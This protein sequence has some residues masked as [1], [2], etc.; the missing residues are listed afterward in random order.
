MNQIQ[1]ILNKLDILKNQ[2]EKCSNL[3][4]YINIRKKMKTER[5]NFNIALG[6]Y[7]NEIHKIYNLTKLNFSDGLE[8]LRNSISNKINEKIKL[9]HNEELIKTNEQPNENKIYKLYENF[10]ITMEKG[11]W[12]YGQRSQFTYKNRLFTKKPNYLD[13]FP[14]KEYPK[15]P[16][17]LSYAIMT[18]D[19]C[20]EIY[21]LMKEYLDY[22]F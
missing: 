11:G 20:L 6:H 17:G 8:E 7:D 10:E 18:L 2:L 13:D 12:A 19:Q 9:Y 5:T 21:A 1:I 22:S 14:I 16:Y 4:E 15:N 3:D